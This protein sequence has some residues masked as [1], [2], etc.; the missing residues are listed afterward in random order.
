MKNTPP[1]RFLSVLQGWHYDDVMGSNK[2]NTF[3]VYRL[4][5]P[6]KLACFEGN[7]EF[8]T[9]EYVNHLERINKYNGIIDIFNHNNELSRVVG[10]QLEGCRGGQKRRRG[11]GQSGVQ[12]CFNSRREVGK[13][14]GNCLPAP[15]RFKKLQHE[16][17]NT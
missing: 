9:T 8:P 11:G 12:H 1:N 17:R 13:G 3:R 6:P 7:G 4:L 16:N 15:Q 2:E 14:R 10:F 5:R